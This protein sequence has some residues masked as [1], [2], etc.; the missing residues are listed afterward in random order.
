MRAGCSTLCYSSQRSLFVGGNTLVRTDPVSQVLSSVSRVTDVLVTVL[1]LGCSVGV[2]SSA[3]VSLITPS[4][5]ALLALLTVSLLATAAAFVRLTFSEIAVRSASMTVPTAFA[6]NLKTGRAS[7]PVRLRMAASVTAEPRP[8]PI[9]FLEVHNRLQDAELDAGI[10][11]QFFEPM[12]C[13]LYALRDKLGACDA[14]A[15]LLARISRGPFINSVVQQPL[16]H[17]PQD[18]EQIAPSILDTAVL[19]R[20][21]HGLTFNLPT[22]VTL[23]LSLNPLELWIAGYGISLRLHPITAVAAGGATSTWKRRFFDHDNCRISGA[24][25]HLTLTYGGPGLLF[26]RKKVQPP[27]WSTEAILSWFQGLVDWIS[28]YLDWLDTDDEIRTAERF[29]LVTESPL[30][31]RSASGSLPPD[32]VFEIE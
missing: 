13:L 29:D 7:P 21:F 4:S 16:S 26:V 3:L 30:H 8:F 15:P 9:V 12:A 14:F 2:F 28:G 11:R 22:G 1:I 18:I 25:F 17:L 19:R 6:V 24:A 31:Y 5:I 32:I 27:K 20:Y 23:R 10:D